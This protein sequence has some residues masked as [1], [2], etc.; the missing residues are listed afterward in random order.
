MTCRFFLHERGFWMGAYF[1]FY[2]SGAFLGPIMSGNIA[3]RHGWRSFFWLT[4]ALAS[5]VTVLLIFFFPETKWRRASVNHAGPKE[6]KGET[7][8]TEEQVDSEA[9]SQDAAGGAVVGQGKPS[10]SQFSPLQKI[11][12]NWWKYIVRDITTPIIV[13]FNPIVFWAAMMLAGP[14]DLLLLFN[15]TESLLF[16]S[17]AYGWNPSQVGYSNFAFFVGGVIGV[18]TAGP[19]SDWYARR[20]T[21]KNNGIREAEMRLPALIPFVIVFIISHIVGAV[22]Y[23]RAWP[24]QAIIVCGFGFS[25]LAVTSIPAISIAYA[26]DCYKPIAGEIMVVGTVMKNVLGF[27][28]SYW[29]F[30]VAAEDGFVAVYMTQF[31]VDMLPVVLTVPLYFYGKSLRRWTKN[32]DI[33]RRDALL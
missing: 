10:K 7:R 25:G 1:T 5:F 26:V 8:V 30:H 33:H 16:S 11:D 12:P 29:I 27:C 3:A 22:G 21:I 24:W 14:A 28:L 17:P 6:G 2:F 31:A 13:F 19:F 20:A 18:L 9:S 32:S 23:Q 15:L 4:V